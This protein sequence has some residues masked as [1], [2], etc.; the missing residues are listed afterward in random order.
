VN[1]RLHMVVSLSLLLTLAS[2]DN[3]DPN[4][5]QLN[6]DFIPNMSS[7]SSCLSDSSAQRFPCPDMNWDEFFTAVTTASSQE[8]GIVYD[9]LTNDRQPWVHMKNLCALYGYKY[10]SNNAYSSAC[11]VS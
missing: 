3:L 6:P 1:A 4:L 2:L 11:A 10:K 5:Q 8:T 9:P 7:S